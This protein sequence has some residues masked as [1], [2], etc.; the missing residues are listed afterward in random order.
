MKGAKTGLMLPTPGCFS[1][2]L[3]QQ[4][5]EDFT[6]S[7]DEEIRP[8]EQHQIPAGAVAPAEVGSGGTDPARS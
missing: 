1:K 2:L 7:G 8:R 6:S 5:A 3:L 4:T